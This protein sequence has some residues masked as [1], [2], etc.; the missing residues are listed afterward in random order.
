MLTRL[1]WFLYGVAASAGATV[2][3]VSK[4][5]AM[6]ERLDA[7]GVARASAL[8]TADGIEAVGRRLQRSSLRVADDGGNGT[9]G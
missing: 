3:I 4:A 2:L 8:V 6:R 5:R 7:Q 9:S 1:R